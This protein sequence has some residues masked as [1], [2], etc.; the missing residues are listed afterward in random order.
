MTFPTVSRQAREH[1]M[2]SNRKS[3]LLHI[4]SLNVLNDLSDEQAGLLFRAIKAYQLGEEV[5]LDSMVKIAFSPFKN[6]F[7]RDDEKYQNTCKARAEAGSKGGKQKVANASKSQ[8]IL[9]K[10]S[11]SKQTLANVADSDS[12][13]DSKSVSDSDLKITMSTSVDSDQV[14]EHDVQGDQPAKPDNSAIDIFHYWC[15]SMRKNRMTSK[16]TPKRMKCI[17]ERLKQGYTVD[18]I[19]TAIYNCSQDPWSMG[20]NDRQKPF[21]DIELICRSGE[22]LESYLDAVQQ[23]AAARNVNSIGADFSPPKG[24]NT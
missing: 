19:K 4:D 11:K 22:K 13:S 20:S 1:D 18:D 15:D 12:D 21:N 7:A 9:A 23:K 16:M 3:F 8:Q 2:A 10:G 17:K 14:I 6:Q 5:E 24:W